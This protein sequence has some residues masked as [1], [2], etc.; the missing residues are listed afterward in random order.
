MSNLIEENHLKRESAKLKKVL[1]SLSIGLKEAGIIESTALVDRAGMTPSELLFLKSL[2]KIAG[3]YHSLS[4][5]E[6]E[7]IEAIGKKL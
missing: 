2:D 3:A 5:T 7:I 4:Q 1:S 6:I